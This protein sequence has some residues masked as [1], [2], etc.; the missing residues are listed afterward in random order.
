MEVGP[1]S[2]QHRIQV[3]L[4]HSV[5][6]ALQMERGQEDPLVARDLPCVKLDDFGDEVLGFQLHVVPEAEHSVLL[7]LVR[8]VRGFNQFVHQLVLRIGYVV[9]P[10]KFL[11]QSLG[12]LDLVLVEAL[13]YFLLGALLNCLKLRHDV[14][15]QGAPVR[16]ADCVSEAVLQLLLQE[17]VEFRLETRAHFL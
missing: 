15:G 13:V 6:L 17:N 9:Q 12:F 2:V 16:S 5:A 10:V 7:P 8:I 4:A 3:L 1:I 14:A 11:G